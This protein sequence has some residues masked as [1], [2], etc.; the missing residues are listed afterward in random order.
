MALI[1]KD[2]T[3][4][5]LDHRVQNCSS[6]FMNDERDGTI[7]IFKDNEFH[8]KVPWEVTACLDFFILIGGGTMLRNYLIL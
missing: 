7:F 2:Y 4:L 5:A 8:I 3:F 6:G 1:F